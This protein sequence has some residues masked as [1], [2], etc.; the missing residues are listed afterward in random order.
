MWKL[1]A[2]P[3]IWPD[4]FTPAAVL[5]EQSVPGTSGSGQESSGPMAVHAPP[6]YAKGWVKLPP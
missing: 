4:P 6:E 5:S 3:T 1:P 2:V